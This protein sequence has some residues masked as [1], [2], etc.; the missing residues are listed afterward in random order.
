MYLA[1]SRRE[2]IPYLIG[3]QAQVDLESAL[4]KLYTILD[5]RAIRLWE[6]GTLN[7]ALL[8]AGLMDEM[9][10]RVWAG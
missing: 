7:G 3:G 1:F 4:N 9:H 5:V 10:Y 2:R 6:G 8:R